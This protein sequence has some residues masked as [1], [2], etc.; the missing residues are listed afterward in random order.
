[1]TNQDA[2]EIL[3]EVQSWRLGS[4]TEMISP[5]QYT[6]ALEVAIRVLITVLSQNEKSPNCD[7][8]FPIDHRG[9]L[10][11]CDFCGATKT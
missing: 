9:K 11:R 7:H 6:E 1:M 8:S 2:L 10:Q 5:R 3:K 4:D